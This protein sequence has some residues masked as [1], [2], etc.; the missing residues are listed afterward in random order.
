MHSIGFVA[1]M[2]RMRVRVRVKP[3]SR[4]EAFEEIEE[5]VFSIAVKEPA[6]RNEANARVR[7]LLARHFHVPEGKVRMRTGARGG[8]KTFDVIH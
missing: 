7:E 3:D 8:T 4:R 6:E 2:L 1:T 5:G